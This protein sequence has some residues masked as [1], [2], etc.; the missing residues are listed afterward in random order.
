[1]TTNRGNE[2]SYLVYNKFEIEETDMECTDQDTN[3]NIELTLITCTN[4]KKNRFVVKCK[5]IT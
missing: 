5:A 1:M 3:G 4:K 2:M